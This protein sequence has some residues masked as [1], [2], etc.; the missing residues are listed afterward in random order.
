MQNAAGIGWRSGGTVYRGLPGAGC[1]CSLRETVYCDDCWGTEAR[2]IA[3]TSR[4]RGR[5]E[6]LNT[7]LVVTSDDTLR[8][9]L[10][11]SLSGFSIFEAP[12]DK[13]ALRTLR[14]VDIDVIVR[15]NTGPLG[16]LATF[17]AGSAAQRICTSPS[18][19]FDM[20]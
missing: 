12:S 19:T 15:G 16:A 3:L 14:L 2:R 13:D 6:P 10:V 8:A 17:V 4:C 7:V 5:G 1:T 18:F 11:R 9:R 20:A